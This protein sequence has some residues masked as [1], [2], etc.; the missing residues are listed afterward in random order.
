MTI[1]LFR[2][3]GFLP[4]KKARDLINSGISALL[5]LVYPPLPFCPAC[6]REFTP[7]YPRLSFCPACLER[8][9][10]LLS[11]VCPRCGRPGEG[12]RQTG[13]RYCREEKRRYERVKAFTLYGGYSKEILQAVKYNFRPDLAKAVGSLMA[14]GMENEPGYDQV[15]AVIPVPLHRRKLAARGYNQALLLAEPLAAFLRAP[16]LSGVLVRKRFTE[17]QS[18]LGRWERKKNVT[19]AF[20]VTN[21]QETAGKSLLLVDDICTTGYTLSECARV[22]LL[23]GARRVECVTAALGAPEDMRGDI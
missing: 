16:L 4:I 20:Q 21:C 5:D 12:N 8:I 9:P 1:I 3:K 19:G 2:R 23:A 7:Y 15:E 13:C 6:G 18:R 17:S 10:F 22:L 11:P 14:A